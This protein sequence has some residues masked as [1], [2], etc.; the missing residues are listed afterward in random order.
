VTLSHLGVAATA[1][2]LLGLDKYQ[3]RMALGIVLNL[4]AGAI[5][6]LWDGSSTFKL[7]QGAAA[8]SGI[9]CKAG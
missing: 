8:R 1:S 2:R 7:G 5:Q 9:F 6:S 3:T 4:I